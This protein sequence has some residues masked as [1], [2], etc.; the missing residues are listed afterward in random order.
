MR[1]GGQIIDQSTI[2]PKFYL[3]S[4]KRLEYSENLVTHTHTQN[5]GRPILLG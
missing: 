1:L 4:T 5:S 2:E 3:E